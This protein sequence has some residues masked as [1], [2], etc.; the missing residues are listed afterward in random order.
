MKNA[1]AVVVLAA[2]A[3]VFATHEALATLQKY[4]RVCESL[5]MYKIGHD[6][7][8]KVFVGLEDITTTST[9]ASRQPMG[10]SMQ[11]GAGGGGGGDNS[12]AG[13]INSAG[14]DDTQVKKAA[15]F[16]VDALREDSKKRAM[17]LKKLNGKLT[18]G[19]VLKA[20]QQVVSGMKY[21]LKLSVKDKHG[22]TAT[23]QAEV[24]A[25]VWLEDNDPTNAW[26]LLSA[27]L[28]K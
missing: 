16:A 3:V 26:Q 8:H 24:W 4:Q 17:G 18:L 2:L 27:S 25:R 22:T 5:T 13:G 23:I 20:S 15:Q 12:Q 1:G 9:T 19:K 28:V 10:D 14:V 11:E 7:L 21:Y 6:R